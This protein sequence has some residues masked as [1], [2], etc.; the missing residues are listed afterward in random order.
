M[1]R[2]KAE[3]GAAEELDGVRRNAVFR[4]AALGR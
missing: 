3:V 2:W 4:P 1:T